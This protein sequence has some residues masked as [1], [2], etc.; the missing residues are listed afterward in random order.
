MQSYERENIR[1]VVLLSHNGVGKTILAE[2][3][4]FKSGAISRL[5]RVEDGNTA[6]DFESEEVARGGSV[7]LA[8]L[9]V[10]WKK[11]KLNIIDT[12]GYADFHG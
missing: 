2:S 4:L 7:S 11:H 9:P 6:S 10:E 8:L 3:M 12:P 5:G 1:N